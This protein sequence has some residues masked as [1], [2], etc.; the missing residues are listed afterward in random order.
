MDAT[1]ILHVGNSRMKWGLYGPRGW[2]AQGALP[3][4]EIG[5]LSL[6]NSGNA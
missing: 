4:A 1:L 2:L 5:T 3:N 6:R